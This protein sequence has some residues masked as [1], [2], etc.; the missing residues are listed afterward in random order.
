MQEEYE[1]HPLCTL[2]PRMSG[3]EF[4]ALVEDIRANGLRTPITLHDGLILDGGNRYRACIEAGIEPTFAKFDGHS[5]V[6]FVLSANLHRRHLSPGQAAAIVASAQDW[7][8]AQTVGNPQW[9][10]VAPLQTA[11]DRSAES[12][13]SLRTQKAADKV[14]K[15]DPE[16]AKAVG[17]GEVSLPAAVAQVEGKPQK[18]KQPKPKLLSEEESARLIAENARLQEV[19]EELAKD[20]KDAVDDN[21]SMAA[22]FE[23]D[24]RLAAALQE[25]EKLR[26]EIRILRERLN[27]KMNECVELNRLLRNARR[28][29]DKIGGQEAA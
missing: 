1:L 8:K 12:G 22:I 11:A 17:H 13:A 19:A 3:G 7:A 25:N 21:A 26:A 27:G 5:I 18:T 14:A 24:D 4:S 20:A 9:C 28:Q 15:A 10:N 6:G 16:L 23:S 2:F 29:L